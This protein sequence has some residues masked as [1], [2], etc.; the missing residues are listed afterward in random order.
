MGKKSGQ[1]TPNYKMNLRDMR[2]HPFVISR[3]TE[4]LNMPIGSV[5][6]VPEELILKYAGAPAILISVEFKGGVLN[7]TNWDLNLI[8]NGIE[9]IS[10]S[11]LISVPEERIE[12]DLKIQDATIELAGENTLIR[13][14]VLNGQL[15]MARITFSVAFVQNAVDVV[16]SFATWRGIYNCS[17]FD[18]DYKSQKMTLRIK[19]INSLAALD[20]IPGDRHAPSI[21]KM[22]YPTDRGLDHINRTTTEEWKVKG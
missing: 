19:A 5:R 20:R 8:Y 4:A 7:L 6:E 13:D 21:Q 12:R 3:Y 9:Y 22:R 14:L 16:G 17:E 10:T 18:V 2:S 11:D 1:S 15:A